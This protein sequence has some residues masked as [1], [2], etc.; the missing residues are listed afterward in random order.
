MQENNIN[1]NN[2]GNDNK[3]SSVHYSTY[4]GLD[5]ILNAQDLRSS[6]LGNTA[7]DE[8]LF[9]IIHQVYELWFKQ[10]GWE[11]D[12]IIEMFNTNQ[13]DEK[14]IGIAVARLNRVTEIEQVLID[15]IRV[16]ETMTSLDFL[17]FRNYLIPA[18]GFQSFQ[19]RVVE[20]KLGLR[21]QNRM[22]Y[23]QKVFSSVFTEEQQNY[24]IELEKQPSLFDLIENWLERIPFVEYNDFNFKNKYLEAVDNM[25]Q[26]EKMAIEST[27]YISEEDKGIR[28]K[29]LLET[30]KYIENSM[31]EEY[32]NAQIAE[33]NIRLSYKATVGALFINLYRDEPILRIPFNLLTKITEVD[34]MFTMWRYRH[35]Q[36][37]IRMLG[38][39]MGT[40]GSS[41][42]TYLKQT[43]EQHHIFRDL[44]NISTLLIP[45]SELPQLSGDLKQKLGFGFEFM[46]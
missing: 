19:F 5:K 24:L 42:H 21:N 45:R 7:H 22:T 39:K 27:D 3:Y 26:R 9:I 4:L 8:M 38:K 33:G 40:G 37:V 31:N 28:V 11:V 46:H 29:M 2:S 10:I 25:T 16:L 14:N 30:Q 44:H 18:S 6:A 32:H 17:D 41:G 36:M 15:Q 34:E 1:I 35:A 20:I 13:I 12:S 23:N 43:A